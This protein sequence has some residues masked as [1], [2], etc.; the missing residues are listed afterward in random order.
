MTGAIRIFNVILMLAVI[1]R[2]FDNPQLIKGII[3]RFI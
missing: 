1:G 2:F 3:S